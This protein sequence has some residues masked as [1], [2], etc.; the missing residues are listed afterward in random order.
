MLKISAYIT[1]IWLALAVCRYAAA[2][3]EDACF[4]DEHPALQTVIPCYNQQ[5]ATLPL[6]F[7]LKAWRAANTRKFVIIG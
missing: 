3:E 6:S 2:K 7:S 1:L 4:A 5:L